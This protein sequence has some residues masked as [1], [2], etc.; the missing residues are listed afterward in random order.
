[1]TTYIIEDILSETST[2]I[3]QEIL[4]KSK[5]TLS[6]SNTSTING[7]QSKNVISFIPKNV[8]NELYEKTENFLTK[9]L[10]NCSYYEFYIDYIHLIHYNTGGYQTGH[11]HKDYEDFAFIIYL[12]NSDGD[13]KIYVGPEII[14]IKPLHS[15]MVF[16]NSQYYH[17]GLSCTNEKKVAV[18]SIRL[19][20]KIWIPR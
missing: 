2:N 6:A 11:T 9:F 18:G 5:K 3:L 15:K 4:E 20:Q 14:N 19:R 7:F 13:T 16:F 17:E 8:L 10:K 1:M 12:N